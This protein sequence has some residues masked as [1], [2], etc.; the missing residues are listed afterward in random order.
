MSNLSLVAGLETAKLARRTSNSVHAFAS[1]LGLPKDDVAHIEAQFRQIRSILR[2]TREVILA[3]FDELGISDQ[4][5]SFTFEKAF[6]LAR[7]GGVDCDDEEMMRICMHA[8]TNRP[9]VDNETTTSGL[10][11]TVDFDSLVIDF[12]AWLSAVMILHRKRLIMGV[13]T[14]KR[15]GG[16]L[17]FLDSQ[18]LPNNRSI[19]DFHPDD[20]YDMHGPSMLES[21]SVAHTYASSDLFDGVNAFEDT[22]GGPSQGIFSKSSALNYGKSSLFQNSFSSGLTLPRIK[23]MPSMKRRASKSGVPLHRK[24]KAS[25]SSDLDSVFDSGSQMTSNSNNPADIVETL[26]KQL[27]DSKAGLAEMNLKVDENIAWIHS[28]CD[29]SN[30]VGI[31][32]FGRDKC[33]RIA[34]NKLFLVFEILLKRSLYF[35]FRHWEKV[36]TTEKLTSITRSFSLVKGIEV[37]SNA[38]GDIVARRLLQG[39][40]PW[41]IQVQN[42]KNWERDIVAVEIQRVAR[43]MLARLSIKDGIIRKA[44]IKIQCM[45]RRR[46]A[47][48]RVSKVRMIKQMATKKLGKKRKGKKGSSSP[49]RSGSNE[50][51]NIRTQNAAIKIQKLHRGRVGRTRFLLKKKDYSVR[52]I[53]KIVRG[54]LARSRVT[55]LRQEKT[56]SLQNSKKGKE[57]KGSVLG[58]LLNPFSPSIKKDTESSS[59]KKSISQLP[60]S[61][62]S[63]FLAGFGSFGFR[64]SMSSLPDE[65]PDNDGN[66]QTNN[67]SN[68][69]PVIVPN[70]QSTADIIATD[71]KSSSLN[72][73]KVTA[74][75][76]SVTSVTSEV[77]QR[78]NT[79]STEI[80]KPQEPTTLEKKPKT[81]QG[82][83]ISKVNT[84]NSAAEAKARAEIEA[85]ELKAK[86]EKEAAEARAKAEKEAA[87]SKSKAKK[88]ASELKTKAQRD[89]AAT[90]AKV[91]K[92]LEE[93]KANAEREA[94]EAK[95]KAEREAQELLNKSQQLFAETRERTEREAEEM[96]QAILREAS[97]AKMKAEREAFEAMTQSQMLIAQE[98]AKAEK[99][100]AELRAKAQREIAEAKALADKETA[101]AKLKTEKDAAE[102]VKISQ[103]VISDAKLQAEKE[104]ADAARR[105]A[106]FEVEEAENL[107]L[108][109]KKEKDDT[110]RDSEKV[111]HKLDPG[112]P[113]S[114]TSR[115][116]TS[117]SM[118]SKVGSFF[119]S[120]TSGDKSR[121]ST[122]AAA[123]PQKPLIELN[124]TKDEAVQ[125]IQRLCRCGV[126]RKKLN[127]RRDLEITAQEKAAMLVLWATVKIQARIA[128]GPIGRVKFY[129]H[130][131][132]KEVKMRILYYN[133]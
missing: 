25:S 34:I 36:C 95:A 104:L 102:A 33:R 9:Q 44:V 12:D 46:L 54:K 72:G 41:F 3:G 75:S 47:R 97:E 30:I 85:A 93:A 56:E 4:L 13:L 81:A 22:G 20:E 116:G 51:K 132:I 60:V 2:S 48:K 58:Q 96:K 101:D 40:K 67:A 133:M 128:R 76:S 125:R 77:N 64:Q 129:K 103:K 70:K 63:S 113:P 16:P 111:R 38:L 55:K 14:E 68:S 84:E 45:V 74:A 32:R 83:Y 118:L 121:P 108:M 106:A 86:S 7:F 1:S 100:I 105:K 127:K 90:K 29:T 43:G 26:R 21:P 49:P 120:F 107:A 61:T 87:D 114:P 94:A 126:A 66:L 11:V 78:P 69:S 17:R 57:R 52:L 15:Q 130:R 124:C 8:G 59:T 24:N 115:P 110:E 65:E 27:E 39:W 109:K 23:S 131:L 53:Q 19:H 18:V 119:G 42:Q 37:L 73:I 62:S 50:L 5:I 98:K 112:P 82:V 6:L 35:S 80:A 123:S 79:V 28:N 31:S 99:E 71:N 10:N 89:A 122:T 117:G 92:E 88:E 91:D